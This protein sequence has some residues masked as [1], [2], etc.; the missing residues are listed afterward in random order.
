MKEHC[1]FK[2]FGAVQFDL[3][4]FPEIKARFGHDQFHIF[5]AT[6]NTGWLY[7]C[8]E[9]YLVKGNFLSDLPAWREKGSGDGV[10][11]SA[12]HHGVLEE[13]IG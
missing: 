9:V 12:P 13:S 6:F 10:V 4:F 7:L 1:L 3:N 8:P 2:F 11:R 5:G